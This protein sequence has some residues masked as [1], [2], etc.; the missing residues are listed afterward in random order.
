MI[1]LPRFYADGSWGIVRN[2]KAQFSAITILVVAGVIV[3]YVLRVFREDLYAIKSVGF[4]NFLNNFFALPGKLIHLDN[5]IKSPVSDKKGFFVDNKWERMSDEPGW[6]GL[7]ISPIQ[8]SM[9]K[10]T[11]I[12]TIL[13]AKSKKV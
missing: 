1:Y 2:G 6:N 9:L 13:I 12:I 11:N 3:G 8:T 7:D 4:L 10:N 5:G